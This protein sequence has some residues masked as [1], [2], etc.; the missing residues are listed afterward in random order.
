MIMTLY[1]SL[2]GYELSVA[3]V[4]RGR[5]VCILYDMVKRRRDGERLDLYT[6]NREGK[7]WCL[8]TRHSESLATG[9]VTLSRYGR[10][11]T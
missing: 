3:I 11:L 9:Y 5:T 8:A 6:E 10:T 1:F 4:L 7:L 2:R